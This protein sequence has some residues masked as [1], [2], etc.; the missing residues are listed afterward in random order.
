MGVLEYWKMDE[1]HDLT[2]SHRLLP[3]YGNVG[4]KEK[5]D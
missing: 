4:E 5:K 3:W 2:F 1:I